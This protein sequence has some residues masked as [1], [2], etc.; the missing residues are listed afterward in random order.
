MVIQP[1]V[2]TSSRTLVAGSARDCLC[3][4]VLA[5]S[6]TRRRAKRCNVRSRGISLKYPIQVDLATPQGKFNTDYG[7]LMT[8]AAVGA[9]P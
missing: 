8:R 1:S 5:T 9:I 6:L 3:K 7:M 2:A 4:D